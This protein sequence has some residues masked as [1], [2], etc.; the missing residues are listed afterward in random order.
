MRYVNL[1]TRA[2]GWTELAITRVGFG[3]W[4]LG[5]GDWAFAWGPQDDAESVAAIRQAVEAGINWIDTAAV[6]GLGH[7][8]EIVGRALR[9]LPEAERPYVFTKCGLVWDD[10]DRTAQRLGWRRPPASAERSRR[11]CGA[12]ASSGSTC[13]NCTGRPQDGTPLEEYWQTFVDL[14]AEGKIRAVGLSNHDVKQ[15]E[16]AEAIGHVD[17]LQPPFSAIHRE[18]AADELPWCAD[19]GTGVI[20]YSPMQAGLLTGAFSAGA[21]R[22]AAGRRLAPAQSRLP[23]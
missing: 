2:L 23:R 5:G 22:G 13:T 20:V 17:T 16:A 21:G 19:H 18:A 7:S 3:A 4:A 14:R 6:Y 11:R 10:A 12:S 1:P 15:L 8:E 9:E